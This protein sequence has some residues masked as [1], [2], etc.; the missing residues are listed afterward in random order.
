MTSSFSSEEIQHLAPLLGSVARLVAGGSQLHDGELNTLLLGADLEHNPT[1][2]KELKL[3][4]RLLTALREQPI[5]EIRLAT[6]ESLLLRGLQEAPVLLAVDTVTSERS[7][8]SLTASSSSVS[9]LQATPSRLD[10]GLLAPGQAAKGVFDIQG[11]PG[12]VLLE[13]DQLRAAPVQF[14][15]GTTRV[16]VE[17]KPLRGGLLWTSLKLVTAGETLEVP[18]LAQWAE[19]AAPASPQH[20][21]APLQQP[22]HAHQSIDLPTM[23]EHAMGLSQVSGNGLEGFERLT[24]QARKVLILAQ[25]E[26][27]RFQHASI[28]TE[29]LLLGLVR[30]NEGVAA[31]I[32]SDLDVTFKKICSDLEF[33]SGRGNHSVS[34]ELAYTPRMRKVFAF[35]VDEA[36]RLNHRS[37]G[38]EHL[39]LG[40][41][42][43]GTGV[44]ARVLERQGIELESVRTRILQVLS[45]AGSKR[46][47]RS[48]SQ[49]QRGSRS[50]GEILA[51][52]RRLLD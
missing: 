41:V 40:V 23:I 10:F 38:T 29:H 3:W 19:A 37:I 48:T 44:A 27:R 20:P 46:G 50:D 36:R 24:E 8:P 30:E 32:L 39:L 6:V 2:L 7:R 11:G 15:S 49:S 12:R 14:G 13:S 45:P 16:Q 51:Q 17:A 18:V 4:G 47:S 34:G 52:L 43:E 42:R 22:A 33:L 9:S 25:E 5:P 28:G 1:I 35:A 21:G 26:A 31:H